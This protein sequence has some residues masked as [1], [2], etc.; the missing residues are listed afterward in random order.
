M[1][2]Q[3]FSSDY[4]LKQ[5]HL[6]SVLVEVFREVIRLILFI[7]FIT[8][9]LSIWHLIHVRQELNNTEVNLKDQYQERTE[10]VKVIRLWSTEGLDET[11]IWSL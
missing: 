3:P 5:D 4:V 6:F 1:L 8:Q 2:N 7:L 9:S 11:Q 10:V